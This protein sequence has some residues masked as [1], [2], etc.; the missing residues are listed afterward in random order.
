VTNQYRHGETILALDASTS[1]L[2]QAGIATT[3]ASGKPDPGIVLASVDTLDDGAAAF[4]AA[5]AKHRHPAHE[6][7]PPRI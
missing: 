3:L 1:L 7:D 5:V 6:T 2:D 4:I